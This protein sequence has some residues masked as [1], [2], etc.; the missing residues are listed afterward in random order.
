MDHYD[1]KFEDLEPCI[2]DDSSMMSPSY[3]SCNREACHTEESFADIQHMMSLAYHFL[4]CPSRIVEEVVYLT[5]PYIGKPLM[6][7]LNKT[8]EGR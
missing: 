6:I 2:F 4:L 5:L 7:H 3:S 1:K 8:K